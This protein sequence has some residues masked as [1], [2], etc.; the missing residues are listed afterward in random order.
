MTASD[1]FKQLVKAG[2]LAE[3]LQM[4]AMS[5]IE[6]NIITWVN[7]AE[8]NTPAASSQ[9]G[10]R[11][12]TKINWIDG[13]IENEIGNLFLEDG[14][15]HELRD[16]HLTQVSQGREIVAGNLQSLQQLF[17]LLT[18]TGRKTPASNL[19]PTPVIEALNPVVPDFPPSETLAE[20]VAGEPP[21]LSPPE[22]VTPPEIVPESWTEPSIE[23]LIPEPLAPVVEGGAE[24]PGLDQPVDPES[25]LFGEDPTI[26]PSPVPESAE[27]PLPVLDPPL[28]PVVDLQPDE[29]PATDLPPP[30]T[31]PEA[32]DATPTPAETE[33]IILSP[34]EGWETVEDD[35]EPEVPPAWTGISEP[36]MNWGTDA[37][38]AE[39]EVEDDL[40]PSGDN[41]VSAEDENWGDEPAPPRP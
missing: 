3:A 40:E 23:P 37:E 8:P 22:L 20:N 35:N 16:F 12:Q 2:R 15:Y 13:D 6:L 5:A 10:Y 33:V 18:R 21:F 25:F 11:M 36:S 4:A 29:E 24:A 41:P 30:E 27:T 39:V 32:S 28:E 34:E 9:P 31:S 26:A 19:P 14:P 17:A 7:D 1:E 38:W